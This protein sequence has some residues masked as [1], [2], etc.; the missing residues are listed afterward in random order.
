MNLEQWPEEQQVTC[1][2][3]MSADT[4]D[5]PIRGDFRQRCPGQVLS[6]AQLSSAMMNGRHRGN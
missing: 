1:H 4:E 2:G 5:G 3:E 6:P